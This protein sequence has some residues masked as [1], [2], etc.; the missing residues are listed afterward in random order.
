MPLDETIQNEMK[1]AMK[2]KDAFRLATLRLLIADMKKTKID[3][4]LPKLEDAEVI[5]ILK[6]QAKQR[7]DSIEQFN[8]AGRT[9]LS[10]KEAGEL[11]VIQE[12]LPE[13][14]SA[15]ALAKIVEEA[16]AET[17]AASMKE[18][19]KVMKAVLEKTQGRADNRQVSEIV[20]SKL[21]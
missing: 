15:E 10:E 14:I 4:Q 8:K 2:N 7:Q 20:K 13:E 3:K 12:F 5:S 11:K 16:I 9:D 18:M 17:G 21:G 6:K 19:G 1:S